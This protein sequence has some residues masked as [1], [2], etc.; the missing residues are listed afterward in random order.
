MKNS[1]RNLVDI[2]TVGYPV[3]ASRLTYVN[4]R[5]VT[6]FMT[7]ETQYRAALKQRLLPRSIHEVS[8]ATSPHRDQRNGNTTS[9]Y[10][11][12]K[13]AMRHSRVHRRGGSVITLA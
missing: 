4:E 12:K 9:E 5:H 8:S 13:K 3:S 1:P 6:N 11:E 2:V 10:E 7:K